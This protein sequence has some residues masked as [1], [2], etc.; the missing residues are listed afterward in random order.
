VVRLATDAALN[1]RIVVWWSE[2]PPRWIQWGDRGY[3][4]AAE[5]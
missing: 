2:D 1:G 5:G 3:R 4:L